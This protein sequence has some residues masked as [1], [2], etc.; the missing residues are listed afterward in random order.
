MISR[1]RAIFNTSSIDS[2][3]CSFIPLEWPPECPGDP[4]RYPWGRSPPGCRAA[5]R[6]QLLLQPADRQHA[7]RNVISPVIAISQ[8]TGIRVRALMIAVARVMPADGP[9]WDAPLDCTCMSGPVKI[10]RQPQLVRARAGVAHGRLAD[11][12]SHRPASG[13]VSFP[14]PSMIVAS[15]VRIC[16][17]LRPCEADRRSDLVRI[18]RL[19]CPELQGARYSGTTPR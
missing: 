16:P 12:A 4:S 15:V 2:T 10:A 5:R 14:L 6:Q 11:P 19:P 8:R 18:Y 9:S 13:V 7:P 17:R 3:K 1:S